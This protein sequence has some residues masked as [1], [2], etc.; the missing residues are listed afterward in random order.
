MIETMNP[1]SVGSYKVSDESGYQPTNTFITEVFG[2]LIYCNC[3]E[4]INPDMYCL[5]KGDGIVY[6]MI[7]AKKL[8]LIT[9]RPNTFTEYLYLECQARRSN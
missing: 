4:W 8:N 6:C 1:K 2:D 3:G 5:Q 9:F 7:C